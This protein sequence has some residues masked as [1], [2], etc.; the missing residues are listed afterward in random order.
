MLRRIIDYAFPSV[1]P[2]M[3]AEIDRKSMRNISIIS[4]FVLMFEFLVL[5]LFL[6]SSVSSFGHHEFVSTV[7]V[8]YCILMCALAVYLSRKL[9]R[10]RSLSQKKCLVFK[11]FFYIAFS[12]WAIFADYRHYRVDEQMLTFYTVNLVMACFVIFRP[13]ISI[14]LS[15]VTFLTLYLFLFFLDRAAGIQPLNF[16]VLALVTVA[17]NMVHYHSH[18]QS[19]EKE[20]SLTESNLAL[21]RASHVDGLTGLRNRLALE[22][23]AAAADGRHTTVF[24]IDINYFKEI[25]DRHGHIVGDQVLRRTSH[26]LGDLFPGAAC[27]RYGG[28][29]FLVL[30]HR[31]AQENYGAATYDFVHADTGTKVSLSIG[32][33]QGDPASYDELFELISRADKSLYVVKKRTHSVEH[34]GHERRNRPERAPASPPPPSA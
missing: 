6:S 14:L 3:S 7:S 24:M 11:V 19:C 30:T 5:I 27:Y 2:D 21:T 25:N 17:C 32:S 34:G 29:E 15:G 26:L 16:I 28:D 8:V 18:M 10:S 9:L 1:D 4:V 31:P 33:A 13:W 22:E 12:F 23:D 20:R